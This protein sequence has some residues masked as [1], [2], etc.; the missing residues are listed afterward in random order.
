M[1]RE[2]QILTDAIPSLGELN[3]AIYSDEI[4]AV[5][6]FLGVVRATEGDSKIDALDY[7]VFESMAQRQFELIFDQIEK[8]WP[9]IASVKVIHRVGRVPVREASLWVEIQSPHRAEAF[10]S[11]QFLIDTMKET[12]P[13]WKATPA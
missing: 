7:E 10:A 13:I 12:V 3:S 11:M 8:K 4:G 2:L 6:S 5:A 1:E 9:Q